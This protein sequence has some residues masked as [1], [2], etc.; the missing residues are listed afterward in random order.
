METK[1]IS[2]HPLNT[3]EN[4]NGPENNQYHALVPPLF[5]RPARWVLERL[6]LTRVTNR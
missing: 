2:S 6:L 3:R 1:V 4:I 5:H